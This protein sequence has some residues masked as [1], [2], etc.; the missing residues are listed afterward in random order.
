MQQQV[1][2]FVS[3]KTSCETE[4]QNVG[5]KQ[6]PRLLD[7]FWR[8]ASGGIM[9]AQALAGVFNQR[10]SGGAAKLPKDLVGDAAN[11]L[12][13]VLPHPQPAVFSTSLRPEIVGGRRVPSRHV[14]SISHMA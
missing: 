7:C 6:M 11:I 2:P 12:L 10:L 4:R 13:Q 8:R 3:C 9:P 5:I 1:W 14:N